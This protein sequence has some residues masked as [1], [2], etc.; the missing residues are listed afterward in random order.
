MLRDDWPTYFADHL[1]RV[2]VLVGAVAL[3]LW[4]RWLWRRQP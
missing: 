2:G 3:G 1:D 4:M